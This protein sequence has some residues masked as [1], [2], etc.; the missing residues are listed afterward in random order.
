[1]DERHQLGDLERAAHGTAEDVARHHVDHGERHHGEEDG[2]SGHAEDEIGAPVHLPLDTFFRSSRNSA[3][4]LA[5]STPLAFAFVIQSSMI[6]AERFLT[7][8]TKAA[9]A[10][11]TFSHACLAA[12]RPFLPATTHGPPA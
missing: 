11:M 4:I 10:V 7:S 2:R 3:R 6:G 5:A 1:Q 8:A 12:S 9:S